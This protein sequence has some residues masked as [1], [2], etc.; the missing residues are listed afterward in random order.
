[1]LSQLAF[2][3]ALSQL[4]Q[5]YHVVFVLLLVSV[6]LLCCVCVWW[7]VGVCGV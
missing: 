6:C 4:S 5:C 7:S 2:E 3:K 1:M